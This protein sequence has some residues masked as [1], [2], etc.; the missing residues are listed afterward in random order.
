MTAGGDADR[1]SLKPASSGGQPLQQ[2]HLDLAS[3]RPKFLGVVNGKI[4]ALDDSAARL[5]DIGSN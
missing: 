1:P 3:H 5:I 4:S 2:K